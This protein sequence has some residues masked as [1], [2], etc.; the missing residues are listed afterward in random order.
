MRRFATL[1]ALTLA[2]AGLNAGELPADMAAKLVKAVVNGTGGKIACRDATMKSALEASGV[3]MDPSAKVAWASNP[4][5][6]KMLKG[7]GKMVIAGRPEML[8][9]GASVAIVEDGGRPKILLH[10]A[11]LAA[12]GVAISDAILKVGEAL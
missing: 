12:S 3:P 9:A 8:S 2:A 7:M 11:N 4:A 1:I 10:R 5:E 6:T